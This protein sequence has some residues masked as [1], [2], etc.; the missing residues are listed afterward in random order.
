MKMMCTMCLPLASEPYG[1]MMPEPRRAFFLQQAQEPGLMAES[2]L[3]AEICILVREALNNCDGS[4]EE[5]LHLPLFQFQKYRF[6][7]VIQLIF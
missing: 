1:Q 6:L 4:D 7:Q 3:V 5:I 2:E